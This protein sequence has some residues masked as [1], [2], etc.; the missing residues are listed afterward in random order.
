VDPKSGWLT[1]RDQSKL[2]REK[3]SMLSLKVYAEEKVLNVAF[4]KIKSFATVEVHL[5]DANDANRN[6]SIDNFSLFK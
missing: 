1:V 3:M 5:L 2:D 6:F 4:G